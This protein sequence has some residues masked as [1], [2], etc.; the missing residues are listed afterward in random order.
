MSGGPTHRSLM[1]RRTERPSGSRAAPR[2]DIEWSHSI[3]SP[4][5]DKPDPTILEEYSYF[6]CLSVFIY[7]Y[8]YV[9]VICVVLYVPW[10]ESV[11][12][13]GPQS[14]AFRA[15]TQKCRLGF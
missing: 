8:I 13:C 10:I 7:I 2:P 12:V 15:D 14:R 9:Y 5:E 1:Q 6:K 4:S 3:P 11:L